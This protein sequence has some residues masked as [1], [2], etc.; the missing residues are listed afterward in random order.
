MHQNR[1]KRMTKRIIISGIGMIV[2]LIST[3]F[4]GTNLYNRPYGRFVI[5]VCFYMGAQ[6]TSIM[7]I[8]AFTKPQPSKASVVPVHQES[9]ASTTVLATR[10]P[11][12][13]LVGDHKPILPVS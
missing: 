13:A 9:T 6:L 4:V 3:A 12:N 5:W 8:F 2:T 1:L 11:L 7:Q 10:K